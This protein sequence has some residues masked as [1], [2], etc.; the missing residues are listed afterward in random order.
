MDHANAKC[1]GKQLENNIAENL[2]DLGHGEDIWDLTPK[3]WSMQEIIVKLDVIKIKNFF[4]T[5]YRTMSRECKIQITDWEKIFAKDTSDKE[6]V[7]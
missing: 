2:G 5:L 7:S 1:K 4:L 3:A 6:L